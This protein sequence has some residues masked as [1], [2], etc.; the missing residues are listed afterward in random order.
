MDKPQHET[1]HREHPQKLAAGTASAENAGHGNAPMQ[2]RH[3]AEE[4]DDMQDYITNHSRAQFRRRIAAL[5]IAS[6]LAAAGTAQAFEIPL[7]TQNLAVRWANTVRY[8]LGVRAQSQDPAILG[9]PNFDD[10]DRNFGNNSIVT[11]RFDV[12]SEF[13]LVWPRP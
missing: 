11:N 10:G 3:F 7:D 2:H 9:A 4:I 6:A 5:A 1:Q 8:N 13:D 12:L